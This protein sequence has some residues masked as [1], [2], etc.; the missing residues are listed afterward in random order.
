MLTVF[1]VDIIVQKNMQ[2]EHKGSMVRNFRAISARY[3][4]SWFAVD[5]LAAVPFSYLAVLFL[6][7]DTEIP[8]YV[9]VLRLIHIIKILRLP[10]IFS[11]FEKGSRINISLIR[12]S[13]FAFYIGIIAHWV[14]CIWTTMTYAPEKISLYAYTRS[15]YW[16]ITTLTTV[17]Y[18]DITPQT[19]GQTIFTIT[20][21]L[22]GVASY[23]YIIGNISSLLAKLD[24]AK[25]NHQERVDK[26]RTF[27]VSHQFPDELQSETMKYF[28]YLWQEK[29][30]YD[31]SSVFADLTDTLKLKFSLQINQSILQKVPLFKNA[32]KNLINEIIIHLEPCIF[33]PGNAVCI[34][35]DMG[36]KMYFIN[37]GS[38]DVFSRDY[39][40]KYTTLKEGSFFG[41][42]SLLL[43]QPRN[44]NIRAADYC[45]LY[46]LD[47]AS[48]DKVIAKYPAFHKEV[49][50]M[51]Q[52]RLA[53]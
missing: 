2:Y 33:L 16:C 29:K 35:G 27:M 20:T 5:V 50:E 7:L 10:G 23:G 14:S 45:E 43:E 44:A 19:F 51:V 41:E 48:F 15:L 38:V 18:G 4:K 30:G 8:S 47:K 40:E 32:S 28:E 42:I 17:G 12:L 36:D 52:A 34:Y 13:T 9:Q 49:Q 53:A 11:E 26:I 3:Y 46:S 37:K 6:P 21:M 24:I 1:F 22:L 39:L 25:A 31:H